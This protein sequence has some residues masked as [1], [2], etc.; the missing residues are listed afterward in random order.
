MSFEIFYCLNEISSASS[1]NRVTSDG[2]A[3]RW[4]LEHMR[5]SRWVALA[6]IFGFAGVA[7]NQILRERRAAHP[8]APPAPRS[9]TVEHVTDLKR[10]MGYGVLSTPALVVDGKVKCQG[11][12]PS[13]EELR[14]WLAAA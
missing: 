8:A 2:H 11:R 5:S 4:L 14:A 7:A 1:T 10:I 12:M 3:Q 13:A 9:A 6:L